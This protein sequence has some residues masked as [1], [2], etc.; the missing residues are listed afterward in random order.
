M[1]PRIIQYHL[2]AAR[3]QLRQLKLDCLIVIDPA[4]ITS[5]TGFLGRESW[6]VLTR[7]NSYLLTDSRYTEQARSQCPCC[8]IIQRT[9]S[10]PRQL[11]KLLEKQKSVRTAAVEASATIA[12]LKALKKHLTIKI[13]LPADIIGPARCIKQAGEIT[14]IR[15]AAKIAAAAFKKLLA[16]VKAPITENELAGLLDW[17]I[18]RAAAKPAFET[19]VAFGPNAARP[20]HSPTGRGLKKNDTVL[21]DFGVTCNGYCCD[22]TRCFT[23]GEPNRF[24]KRAHDAVCKAQAAAIKMVRPGV[25]THQLDSAARKIIADL[26]LPVYGHGTG[27]GL[28]L[29]VHELPT[30]AANS[31]G[32][33][34]TG[35]VFTIEPA[36]YIPGKFG[37]R[38]EDDILV[39]KSGCEILTR[40]CPKMT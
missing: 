34:Q 28:G 3:K 37:I 13:K 31:Q 15:T 35:Q 12:T 16:V 29:Q 23:V 14:Y 19:I 9:E 26:D 32:T 20:H 6:A 36:V 30:I 22:I 10:L 5:L 11:A 4:N 8:R 40:S 2:K 27:H 21:I 7:R 24:Y 38:I 25:Q 1:D 33:L 18:R 39:T 17:E